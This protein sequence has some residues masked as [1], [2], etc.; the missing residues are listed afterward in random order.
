MYIP[1]FV[2]KIKYAMIALLSAGVFLT[3][4]AGIAM[5]DN[6]AGGATLGFIASCFTIPELVAVGQNVVFAGGQ[7]G[8]TGVVQYSWVGAVHGNGQVQNAIFGSSGTIIAWLRVTDGQNRLAF[9]S[10][11]LQV[12]FPAPSAAAATIASNTS[13]GRTTGG[14]RENIA[15]AKLALAV[16]VEGDIDEAAL[17]S[18]SAAHKQSLLAS[19]IPASI[20]AIS[21]STAYL[22][23]LTLVI[24]GIVAYLAV[25]RKKTSQLV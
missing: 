8:G 16:E 19:V 4:F 7:S 21:F 2:R 13:G 10:C 22:L 25:T 3:L 18:D 6:A 9:A 15:P 20:R 23:F 17:K 1:L 5:A 11:S 12:A 24:F 14:T